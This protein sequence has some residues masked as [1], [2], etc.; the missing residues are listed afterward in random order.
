MAEVAAN[1]AAE[2]SSQLAEG[3]SGDAAL[4]APVSRK[5]LLANLGGDVVS[6]RIGALKEHRKHMS[7]E[8][9]GLAK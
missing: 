7:T 8:Q 9:R 2:G 5:E 1:A 6:G 3:R 4:G